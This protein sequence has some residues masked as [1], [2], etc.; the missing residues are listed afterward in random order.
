MLASDFD[1]EMQIICKECGRKFKS[2]KSLAG[3]I[4]SSE[5]HPDKKWAVHLLYGEGAIERNDF[6]WR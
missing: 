5:D 1:E 3:H 6:M 4:L 2:W